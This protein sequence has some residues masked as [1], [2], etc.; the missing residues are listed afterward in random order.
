MWSSVMLCFVPMF[1][2]ALRNVSCMA[3]LIWFIAVICFLY[4]SISQGRPLWKKCTLNE[5]NIVPHKKKIK[6]V[7]MN[8]LIN[9][10]EVRLNEPLSGQGNNCFFFCKINLLYWEE[11]WNLCTLLHQLKRHVFI[12]WN[13]GITKVV[14]SLL[15]LNAALVV[16]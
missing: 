7:H 1:T 5:F 13:K 9:T 6:S 8:P 16:A 14:S 10:H 11:K 4:T 2:V 15:P 3:Q 12:E